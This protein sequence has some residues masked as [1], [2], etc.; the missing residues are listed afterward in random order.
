MDCL[1]RTGLDISIAGGGRNRLQGLCG[2]NT[3][4]AGS[5]PCHDILAALHTVLFHLVDPGHRVTMAS[6]TLTRVNQQ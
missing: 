6:L 4:I 1:K 2:L 3:V 5:H